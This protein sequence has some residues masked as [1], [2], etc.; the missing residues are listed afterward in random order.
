MLGTRIIAGLSG[1]GTNPVALRSLQQQARVQLRIASSA[2]G[3]FHPKFY[4]FHRFSE[5]T[6][7]IGSSNLTMQGFTY[8]S[9]LIN[10]FKDDGTSLQWFET[11]WDSLPG[12]PSAIIDQYEQ[13]WRRSPPAPS[14]PPGNPV[15]EGGSLEKIGSRLGLLQPN[16]SWELY[17]H[18]I[19]S[20]DGYWARQRFNHCFSVLSDEWSWVDTI[21]N[22]N[23]ISHPCRL[24]QSYGNRKKDPPWNRNSGCLRSMGTTGQY[25]WSAQRCQRIL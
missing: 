11:V 14:R 5:R 2:T 15:P 7:W 16:M 23:D 21:S 6:C 25:A 9:E 3:I 19:R 20:L 22:G 10:E 17:V 13:H 8:N 24:G 1:N 12:D 18:A 4:L